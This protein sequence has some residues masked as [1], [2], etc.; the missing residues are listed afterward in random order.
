MNKYVFYLILISLSLCGLRAQAVDYQLDDLNGKRQ[1]LEQYRGQWVVVNFWASWCSTCIKEIPDLVDLHQQGGESGIVVIGVNYED[2]STA[3]LKKF[4]SDLAIP[5]PIWRS[6]LVPI[7]PLGRV[8]A[9][10]TTYI[11]NPE[12][13]P[14]A[15]EVGIVS[16][17]Q[18]E[19]YILSKKPDIR[20]SGSVE[21]I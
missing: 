19:A 14:V 10:P 13:H 3:R 16:R 18:I 11:I 21:D 12:G 17:Q 8:P 15:G 4:V 1:S 2:I 9:L 6:E 20:L 7:T 5:Y